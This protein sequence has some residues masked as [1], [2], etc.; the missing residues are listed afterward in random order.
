MRCGGKKVLVV[1]RLLGRN[2]LHEEYG[3]LQGVIVFF[4]FFCLFF[5]LFF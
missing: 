5:F 1:G 4:C 2:G 3:G